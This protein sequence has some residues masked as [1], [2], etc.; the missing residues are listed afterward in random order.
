MNAPS[1]AARIERRRRVRSVPP[2][3]D[4]LARV[5]ARAGSELA[6][7]DLSD[8]GALLEGRHRLLPGVCLDVHVMTRAGRVLVRGRVVRA[9]V[10]ALHADGVRY[11]GG[12]SFDQ[13]VD[14]SAG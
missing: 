13:P 6:V 12:L 7:I 3:D 4:P 5:R 14:T 1:T 9:Y 2:V 10:C 11:R 8:L